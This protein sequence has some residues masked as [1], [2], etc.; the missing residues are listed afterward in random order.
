MDW[1][2]GQGREEGDVRWSGL[3]D[4]YRELSVL[5]RMLQERLNRLRV[6]KRDD[7]LPASPTRRSS[8]PSLTDPPHLTRRPA[9][10]HVEWIWLPAPFATLSTAL[11]TSSITSSIAP[12]RCGFTLLAFLPPSPL[13]SPSSQ[14][15]SGTSTGAGVGVADEYPAVPS[16]VTGPTMPVGTRVERDDPPWARKVERDRAD[17]EGPRR[18]WEEESE[19]VCAPEEE[20]EG[21][22]V[23]D[24]MTKA[25]YSSRMRRRILRTMLPDANSEST[26]GRDRGRGNERGELTSFPSSDAGGQPVSSASSRVGTYLWAERL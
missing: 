20:E 2:R 25:R 3:G 11:V 12:I 15:H 8:A 21:W 22:V 16:P 17:E 4:D 10:T 13:L 19:G 14:S 18:S 7:D 26:Q 24:W 9:S 5:G 1:G 23:W 6:S